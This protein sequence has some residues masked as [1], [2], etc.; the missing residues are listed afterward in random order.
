M[1]GWAVGSRRCCL[2]SRPPM[3][4]TCGFR[5]SR[6]RHPD[7]VCTSLSAFAR[8]SGAMLSARRASQLLKRTFATT[9]TRRYT[10]LTVTSPVPT[11]FDAV[12]VKGFE[13]G[14]IP[15]FRVIGPEGVPLD[16]TGQEQASKADLDTL[17]RMLEVM[18]TLPILVRL[19]RQ[20][21]SGLPSS[22]T[23]SCLHTGPDPVLVAA[24]GSHFFLHDLV[25]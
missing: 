11:F 16:A 24:S 23:F 22:R 17:E 2:L 10:P 8:T 13:D 21:V 15:A 19:A 25:R 14:P 7:S 9:A 20:S 12:R 6:R 5:V 4:P 1:D 18:T 3:C